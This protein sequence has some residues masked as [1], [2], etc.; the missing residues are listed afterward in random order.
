MYH[1]FSEYQGK[2]HQLKQMLTRSI[3]AFLAVVLSSLAFSHHSAVQFDFSKNVEVKGKIARMDVSNP[4]VDLVLEITNADGS[5]KEVQFEGH[6]RNN[7]YR[8]GWRTGMFEEGDMLT[9]SIAPM[10]NGEDGGYIQGYTLTD[11]TQF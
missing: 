3:F 4:H 2:C 9:I 5:T 7:I 10:R 1:A 11:G 6:S 8:R